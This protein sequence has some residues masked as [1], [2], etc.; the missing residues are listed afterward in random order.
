MIDKEKLEVARARLSVLTGR[1]VE[2]HE[3]A[4]WSKL[5]EQT[6]A[7]LRVGR[8]HGSARSILRLIEMFRSRGV[9]VSMRDLIN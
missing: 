4:K 8:T 2:W 3:V 1:H 7:N 5:S 9:A 6:I